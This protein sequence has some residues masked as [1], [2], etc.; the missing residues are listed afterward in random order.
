MVAKPRAKIL[1]FHPLSLPWIHTSSPTPSSPSSSSST[2]ICT[3]CSLFSSRPLRYV[4][5]YNHACHDFECAVSSVTW[6][7]SKPLARQRCLPDRWY[8]MKWIPTQFDFIYTMCFKSEMWKHASSLNFV[9]VEEV[10]QLSWHL[11][12]VIP[13]S[14]MVQYL[15][16]VTVSLKA[17]GVTGSFWGHRR[18]RH[19]NSESPLFTLHHSQ[20]P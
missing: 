11:H 9:S 1:T 20:L 16:A 18:S 10:R 2:H 13:K 19:W 12:H 14:T 5:S 6:R 3:S 17:L 15:P 8:W 4:L 7:P